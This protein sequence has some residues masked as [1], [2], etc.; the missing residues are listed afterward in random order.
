MPTEFEA[1]LL[2]LAGDAAYHRGVAY[3]QD[4][5]VSGLSVKGGRIA[6]TVRGTR[7]YRVRLR[8]TPRGLEGGCDCP[9][10]EGF[11]FCKHCVAVGLAVQERDHARA[12]AA[13]GTV[14]DRVRVY[15]SGLSPDELVDLL[16]EALSGNREL[17][18]RIVMRADLATG[19]LDVGGLKKRIT[20]AL[21]LRDVWHYRQ[22]RRYFERARAA[23]DGIED[24]A[25]QLPAEDLLAAVAHAIGR[26]NRVLGRVDDS[27]GYRFGVQNALRALHRRALEALPWTPDEKAG[28][29]LDLVL[30]DDYDF[31]S[32]APGD[33]S[34]TLG[35]AGLE[36]FFAQA[37]ARF[38]ALPA[39]AM[40]ADFDARRP[41][42]PLAG[43]LS[44]KAEEDGD[45]ARLIALARHIC[46]DAG[47]CY[48]IAEL[49][50]RL[51]DHDQA[52]EWLERGDAAARDVDRSGSGLRVRVHAARGEWQEA[53][54]A[55]RELFA[56][57]PTWAAYR[58]L[59]EL[60]ARAGRGDEE[61]A[62][63][64]DH[65]RAQLGGGARRSEQCAMTLAAALRN[66]GR[67]D[68]AYDL[69]AG[70]V[71]AQD[72]LL[73]AARWYEAEHPAL[74]AQCVAGAIEDLIGAKTKN[75]YQDAVTL[76]ID[77]RPLFDRV[78]DQAYDKLVRDLLLRHRAK[79]SL[80]A[81]LDDVH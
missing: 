10:S 36:A 70:H 18:E 9:A 54:S 35:A 64:E 3:H 30:E 75:G 49:Y 43:L 22:V 2:R 69:V 58:E 52:L 50:L 62:W 20:A 42:L 81:R 11:D 40:G 38:D 8:R 56:S 28:H 25:D 73:E 63:A 7:P 44:A 23:I 48:R 60:A 27:G 21:P 68:E 24:V 53:A 61:A 26:L 51:P 57:N 17:R 71:F 46:T 33:Y 77:S 74:A 45:V 65:L 15:L 78:D 5:R 16:A 12:R 76:L 1:Q 79:R 59:V 72:D 14:D 4:G 6:A 13:S 47:D 37:Q 34:D 32:G 80:V 55:Q 39:L 19:V 29:L 31:F 67:L 41:Y 66:E